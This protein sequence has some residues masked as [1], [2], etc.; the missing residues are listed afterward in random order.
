MNL[1]DPELRVRKELKVDPGS[2]YLLLDLER[3]QKREGSV[4]A[5]ACKV[6]E[7]KKRDGRLSYF[8]EGVGATEAVVLLR[9]PGGKHPSIELSDGAIKKLDYDPVAH[10]AWIRFENEARPRELSVRF[11]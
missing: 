7:G 3:V 6:V 11:N 2:R 9:V 10:L 5:A 4:L 1:F 8:V